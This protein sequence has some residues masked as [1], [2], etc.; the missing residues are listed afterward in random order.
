M[1][2]KNFSE[3]D[4]DK[5]AKKFSEYLDAANE[6]KKRGNNDYNPLKAVQSENDEV[7]MHSG[8]LVSLLDT[9]GEH[10]QDDLFLKLFLQTLGLENWFGET[11]NA[12][13]FKEKKN[14]DIHINNG[15]KHI[16]IENKIWSGDQDEQIARYINEIH[17]NSSDDESVSYENIAVVY[18]SPFGRE[19]NP[20][21]L[22]LKNKNIKWQIKGDLLEFNENKVKYKQI[23][24]EKDILA[25]IEKC[26]KE[27]GDIT[28]LNSAL[29][30]YKDIV[31]IITDKKDS[32]MNVAGFF[33]E[34]KDFEIAFE[35]CKNEDEIMRAYLANIENDI[36]N[37][38]EERVGESWRTEL[39]DGILFVEN[40]KYSDEL[41]GF[42]FDIEWA[43]EEKNKIFSCWLYME[44]LSKLEGYD[45]KNMENYKQK[46]QKH[47]SQELNGKELIIHKKEF[48]YIDFKNIDELSNSKEI[49][50]NF[51]EKYTDLA[52]K[53]NEKLKT[54]KI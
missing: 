10:Y 54:F 28:S 34:Q 27:V 39:L 2:E 26:Q 6:S 16:I 53:L 20:N 40:E 14:I 5:F 22:C 25:W 35:I 51:I 49:F 46:L 37:S 31:E 36:R 7:N 47:L 44:G 15:E 8:F 29:E 17:G 12:Q 9:R 50:L 23:S 43:I 11:K 3:A 45:K 38:V 42:I 19:P 48:I 18:L 21:S 41:V 1:S 24:Y 33:K 4:F 30:F 13:V 32:K 52:D